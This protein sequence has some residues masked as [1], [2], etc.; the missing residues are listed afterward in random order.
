M[1]R[2]KTSL[3]LGLKEI[4]IIEI[5]HKKSRLHS[6]GGWWLAAVVKRSLAFLWLIIIIIK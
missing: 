4:R 1:M 3:G 5:S 2:F 6:I